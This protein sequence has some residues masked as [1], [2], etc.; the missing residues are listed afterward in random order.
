MNTQ[1]AKFWQVNLALRKENGSKIERNSFLK[2]FATWVENHLPKN[3]CPLGWRAILEL[4]H[5]RYSTNS[6]KFVLKYITYLE[7]IIMFFHK[8]WMVLEKKPFITQS[9]EISP[10]RITTLDSALNQNR[11]PCTIQGQRTLLPASER[12]GKSF[13]HDWKYFA[14]L[15]H[16]WVGRGS[17][18]VVSFVKPSRYKLTFLRMI[19]I[20]QSTVKVAVS[21]G[22]RSTRVLEQFCFWGTCH[23]PIKSRKR[24]ERPH[25]VHRKLTIAVLIALGYFHA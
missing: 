4:S 24:K 17:V 19:S 11:A 10:L 12:L 5:R 23:E 7:K 25:C 21:A 18:G 16:S 8:F 1:K 13:M 9:L 14:E 20:G 3:F 6:I 22:M 15:A 2:R